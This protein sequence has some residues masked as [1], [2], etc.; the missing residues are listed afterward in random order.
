MSS[1]RRTSC[2]RGHE[3]HVPWAA[4]ADRCSLKAVARLICKQESLSEGNSSTSPDIFCPASAIFIKSLII[5]STENV[6]LKYNF[7]SQ[8]YIQLCYF[9]KV[10]IFLKGVTLSIFHFSLSYTGKCHPCCLWQAFV[11]SGVVVWTAATIKCTG[12]ECT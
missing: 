11:W 3:Q 9:F 12:M 4:E 6:L 5:N 2:R 8:G 10:F 7:S 1:V